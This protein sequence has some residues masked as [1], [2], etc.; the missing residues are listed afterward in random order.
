MAG[1]GSEATGLGW[2][3]EDFI[4][5]ALPDVQEDDPWSVPSYAGNSK[6]GNTTTDLTIDS[7]QIHRSRGPDEATTSDPR[8]NIGTPGVGSDDVLMQDP[9][10]PELQS[11]EDPFDEDILLLEAGVPAPDD[12]FDYLDEF[13]IDEP[14]AIAEFDSDL[15]EVLYEGSDSNGELS[16][17]LKIDEFIANVEGATSDEKSLCADLLGEFSRGRLRYW[18][19]WLRRQFWTGKS[20]L[21]F[22]E[23]RIN[24]WEEN[25][26]WWEYVF[27]HERMGHWWVYLNSSTLSLDATYELVHLRMTYTPE[28]VIDV[29]WLHDWNEYSPW[30]LGVSSFAEFVLFRAGLVRD[31]HWLEI[32]RSTYQP[33]SQQNFGGTGSRGKRQSLR[34]RKL[35]CDSRL[36]RLG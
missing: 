6:E 14:E 36:A 25:Q 21:Q 35:V 8:L 26:D 15:R 9:G 19:N 16:R 33:A 23:F 30:N 24:H 5:P 7:S 31:E 34:R 1:Y 28:Q 20:L 3:E 12:E 13:E 29:G 32:L 18:L 2:N 4:D 27:W 11:E 17:S 22:L 10:P